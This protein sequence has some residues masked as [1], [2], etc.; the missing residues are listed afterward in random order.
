MPLD[1]FLCIRTPVPPASA[2]P[3]PNPR[4]TSMMKNN[5]LM[6]VPNMVM[7][8]WL[9]YFFSGF[10]IAKMPFPLTSRFRSMLQRG[11]R[12]HQKLRAPR[13]WMVG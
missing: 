5:M 2:A 13:C 8:P 4:Q 9:S 3:P 7:L 11:A 1:A 6:I 12:L 10:V